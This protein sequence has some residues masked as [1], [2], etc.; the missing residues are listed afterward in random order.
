[1]KHEIAV[2]CTVSHSYLSVMII[3]SQEHSFW[4]VSESESEDD[5]NPV[6]CE[7]E[8]DCDDEES[9]VH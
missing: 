1:M 8:H 4:E 6:S 5:T 7:E 2:H 9:A 3:N